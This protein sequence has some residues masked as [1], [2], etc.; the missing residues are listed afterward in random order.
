V[1]Q[2]KK[3]WNCMWSLICSYD[4]PDWHSFHISW[5]FDARHHDMVSIMIPGMTSLY[6]IIDCLMPILASLFHFLTMYQTWKRIYF[7]TFGTE[8]TTDYMPGVK[9]K[10]NIVYS[11]LANHNHLTNFDK[12]GILI[13][14]GKLHSYMFQMQDIARTSVS[15]Y[16]EFEFALFYLL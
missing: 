15:G 10:S 6:H 9:N 1:K 14:P 3:R 2:K 12:L 5:F 4:R 13:N 16:W 11:L 7:S 8:P